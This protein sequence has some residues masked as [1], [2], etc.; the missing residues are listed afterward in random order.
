MWYFELRRCTV[1][2]ADQNLDVIQGVSVFFFFYIWVSVH[3]KSIICNKPT[4]CNSGSIVFFNNYR[5][6]LH[7]SDA[8][9][10]IGTGQVRVLTHAPDHSLFG[11]EIVQC[12]TDLEHPYRIYSIPTHDKHQWLLLQFIV[13]L[14]MDAKG[15]WNT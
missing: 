13:L 1:W 8:L 5:Y 7:V 15:I 14:M 2:L 11:H 4:R 6:A 12:T 9:Y 10:R 3:H